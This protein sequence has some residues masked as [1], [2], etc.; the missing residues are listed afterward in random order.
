[1]CIKLK[2]FQKKQK[3]KMAPRHK[4]LHVQ[5]INTLKHK[6]VLTREKSFISSCGWCSG[7]SDVLTFVFEGGG[8]GAGQTVGGGCW[9]R[10]GSG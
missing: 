3:C 6:A 2:Q 8:V 4:T 5:T 9:E 7:L 10:N 1:M